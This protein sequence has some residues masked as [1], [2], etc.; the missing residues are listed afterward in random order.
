MNKVAQRVLAAYLAA[1][2]GAMTMGAAAPAAAFPTATAIQVS[3]A[4]EAPAEPLV[5]TFECEVPCTKCVVNAKDA[6]G[7]N[8]CVAQYHGCCVAAGK[9]GMSGW[10]CVCQ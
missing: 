10:S 2:V 7:K 6:E 5:T 3:A 1:G 8:A 9:K 4:N